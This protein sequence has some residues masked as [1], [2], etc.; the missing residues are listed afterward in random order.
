MVDWITCKAEAKPIAAHFGPAGSLIRDGRIPA[1]GLYE[2]YR[3]VSLCEVL[4][5]LGDGL[6]SE[7]KEQS[8]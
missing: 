7:T 8:Q 5:V 1:Y 6:H 4:R 2:R 3:R